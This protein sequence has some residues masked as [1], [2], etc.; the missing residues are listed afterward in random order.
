MNGKEARKGLKK[1]LE[2]ALQ[3]CAAEKE[4]IGTAAHGSLASAPQAPVAAG[5][6]PPRCSCSMRTDLEEPRWPARWQAILWPWCTWCG[7]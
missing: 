4:G 1:M 2:T 3:Q 6:G 5:Q 7:G